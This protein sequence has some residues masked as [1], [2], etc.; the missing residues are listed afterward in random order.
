MT[1]NYLKR[2]SGQTLEVI[3]DVADQNQV[4]WTGWRK[5]QGNWAV[6]IGRWMPR[7]EVAGDICL[8]MPRLRQGCR[9]DDDDDDDDDDDGSVGTVSGFHHQGTEGSSVGSKATVV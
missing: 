2:Y 9:A 1:T 6:E 5:T 3:K 8:R 4:G 7:V